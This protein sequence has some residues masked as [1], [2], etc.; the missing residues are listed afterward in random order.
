M[1]DK[2]FFTL[3]LILIVFGICGIVSH[4]STAPA[5]FAAVAD[6]QLERQVAMEATIAAATPNPVELVNENR[7]GLY[8]YNVEADAG[9]VGWA[10][11]I[12]VLIVFDLLLILVLLM[13][14]SEGTLKQL[15][16]LQ[17]QLGG[18]GGR[19]RT[20]PAGGRTLPQI[21]YLSPRPGQYR[22]IP[23]QMEQAVDE[24]VEW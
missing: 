7:K 12:I 6:R 18:G 15:R 8:E 17:K 14:N 13:Q 3:V 21:P 4:F 1:S 20:I 5:E 23:A 22:Q 19:T 24:E 10:F 9:D 2:W 16:M 11:I